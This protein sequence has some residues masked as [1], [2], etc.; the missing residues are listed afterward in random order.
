MELFCRLNVAKN[1]NTLIKILKNYWLKNPNPNIEKC[2]NYGFMNKD[3]LSKVKL[4]SYILEKNDHLYY[5]YLI[6]GKYKY[7]AKIWGSSKNELQK[8]ITLKPSKEAYYYL[9]KVNIDLKNNSDMIE[10][11]KKLYKNSNNLFF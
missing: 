4:T 10:N 9:Y 3:A 5:K 2:I 11:Y 8:S 6:L 1:E 7:K